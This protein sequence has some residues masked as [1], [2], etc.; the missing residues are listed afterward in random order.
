MS[1]RLVLL[2]AALVGSAGFSLLAWGLYETFLLP[3]PE[4]TVISAPPDLVVEDG[5]PG[6]PTTPGSSAPGGST[7]ATGSIPAPP[8]TVGSPGSTAGGDSAALRIAPQSATAD[9]LLRLNGERAAF[10]SSPLRE[11]ATLSEFALEWA[12]EM[13][14]SGYKHSSSERLSVILSAASLSSVAENIH[15]PEP[16]CPLAATCT[17]AAFQPTTGVLHV[18]WMRSKQHRATALQPAWSR[19][20]VGVACDATGRMWAVLVFGSA[21]GV[22][23]DKSFAPAMPDLRHPGNDGVLCDGSTRE[24]NPS[25][26]HTSPT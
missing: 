8:P 7:G 13:A 26:R 16:Q 15:A 24:S 2:A 6:S 23:R 14:V 18:D 22:T 21:P 9:L 5:A 25:W 10:G 1:R 4:A 11:D 17:E 3:P 12:E 20:G 19:V